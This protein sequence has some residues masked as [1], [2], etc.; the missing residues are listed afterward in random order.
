MAGDVFTFELFNHV[1]Q[2]V[3]GRIYIGIINLIG[4]SGQ[5]N[6]GAL[7]GAGNNCFDFMR[8]QVLRLID[9]HVL[10]GN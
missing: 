1:S 5:D 8:R 4:I 7:T 10:F 2:A 3:A 6:L 9:D